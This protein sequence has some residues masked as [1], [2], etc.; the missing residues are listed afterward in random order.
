MALIDIDGLPSEP[1]P[2]YTHVGGPLHNRD[3]LERI[4]ENTHETEI[5][6]ILSKSYTSILSEE[7][8][9]GNRPLI[10]KL[11]I[12]DKVL[13]IMGRVIKE[14][15]DRNALTYEQQV[16]MNKIVYSMIK[17]KAAKSEYQ[18]SLLMNISRQANRKTVQLL[19]PYV[20]EQV[21]CTIAVL[22]YSSFKEG[23]NVLRV[24]DYLLNAIVPNDKAEQTI[25]HIY[26]ALYKRVT[27]LFEGIMLDVKDVTE[28]SDREKEIYG[29]QSLAVLDII[30][31]MPSD[32]IYQVLKTYYNDLSLCY[33]G[34]PTRFSL[35]SINASDYGRIVAVD[36]RLSAEVSYMA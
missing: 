9:K 20:P 12:Q 4:D 7:Y 5:Y 25:V 10:K 3:A 23:T 14:L 6:D 27:Y 22:R 15:A 2:E 19:I 31:D 29:Y 33:T 24:N 8:V 32:F 26:D 16:Y 21:A 17:N 28:L 11:F 35:Q 30:N 36:K 34:M 1:K 13:L 18:I